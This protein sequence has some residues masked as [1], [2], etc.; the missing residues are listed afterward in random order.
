MKPT[1]EQI[2]AVAPKGYWCV[3]R[4]GGRGNNSWRL[5]VGYEDSDEAR[6]DFV[7][8]AQNVRQGGLALVDAGGEIERYYEAPRVRT[9]W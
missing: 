3:L 5:A 6:G 8:R 9:R 7:G 4:H 1:S 2:A